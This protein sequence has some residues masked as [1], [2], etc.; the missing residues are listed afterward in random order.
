MLQ[1]PMSPEKRQPSDSAGGFTPPPRS[2][3]RRSQGHSG[4]KQSAPSG[5]GQRSGT[6][7]G[8]RCKQSTSALSAPRRPVPD[9]EPQHHN[10]PAAASCRSGVPQPVLAGAS[11]CDNCMPFDDL[12]A[13]HRLVSDNAKASE[14]QKENCELRALAQKLREQLAGS[15]QR[16]RWYRSTAED[17]L[18]TG[19]GSASDA[20]EPR[21]RE[22]P[23]ESL[24][25]EDAIALESLHR[26]AD[27]ALQ[28]AALVPASR[29]RRHLISPPGV[30]S[31]VGD[32]QSKLP[33]QRGL[34]YEEIAAH[35]LPAR[36]YEFSS[37]V[38]AEADG[39]IDWAMPPRNLWA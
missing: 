6:G 18:A 23:H 25:V 30:P 2:A 12:C 27:H 4:I 13:E 31:E 17:L 10:L 29:V 28:E 21:C 22:S 5:S 3:L 34:L 26:R 7:P 36:D 19:E 35:H 15:E 8:L 33:G 1:H 37:A 16:E 9:T 32:D 39:V 24:S 11:S 20:E 14:L 38:Q